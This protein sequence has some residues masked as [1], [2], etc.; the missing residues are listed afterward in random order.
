MI[1]G[2]LL[3]VRECRVSPSI[4]DCLRRF[5]FSTAVRT[6]ANVEFLRDFVRMSD[7]FPIRIHTFVEPE[8]TKKFTHRIVQ[9]RR[10]KLLDFV[11]Q[12]R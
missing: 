2:N 11:L 3:V 7:D 12:E 5:D 6:Q 8:R 4:R 1:N 9:N 10:N